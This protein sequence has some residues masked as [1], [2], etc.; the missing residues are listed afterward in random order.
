MTVRPETLET[1]ARLVQHFDPRLA[2][3][4]RFFARVSTTDCVAPVHGTRRLSDYF[5]RQAA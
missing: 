5:V 3:L 1:N 2:D 4:L